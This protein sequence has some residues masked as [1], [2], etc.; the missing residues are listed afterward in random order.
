MILS[1]FGCRVYNT[2]QEGNAVKEDIRHQENARTMG[3]L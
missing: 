3:L 1:V 2:V